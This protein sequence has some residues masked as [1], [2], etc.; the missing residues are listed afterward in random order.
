MVFDGHDPK[1]VQDVDV[2]AGGL[3]RGLLVNGDD[4]VKELFLDLVPEVVPSVPH[5][6]GAVLDVQGDLGPQL[7]ELLGGEAVPLQED[8]EGAGVVAVP[9]VVLG[10]PHVARHPSGKPH[11]SQTLP[12]SLRLEHSLE[13]S[14]KGVGLTRLQI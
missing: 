8:L 6:L 5:D 14:G 9:L 10:K 11:L 4:V 3:P 13:G 2:L 1:H 12:P 7:L